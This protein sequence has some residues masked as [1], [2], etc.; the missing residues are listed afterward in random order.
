MNKL[1]FATG[2]DAG[3][4][5]ARLT[6]GLIIFPHGAQKVF[7]WFNGPGFEKEMHFFTTQLHLPWL[8]GLMVII[9]EFAGS[10]CLLAGLA[11]RCWALAT[12]ALFT[13]IIL[14]EHL[15]FGFFMNWFGNQKGEGFEYHLL[16]IGLALIVLL[17]GAGSLSADR[18]IMPAAGRK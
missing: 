16:V 3:A 12:I 2:R 15:Q 13:G 5:I 6:L 11:A 18:L 8:V 14:L 7:G 10:L 4:V 9:T 17:K 1:L